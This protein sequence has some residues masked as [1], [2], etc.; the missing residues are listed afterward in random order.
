MLCQAPWSFRVFFP[1]G[2]SRHENHFGIAAQARPQFNPAGSS[3]T[4]CVFQGV[5]QQVRQHSQQRRQQ[6][7]QEQQ[8][9]QH[10]QQQQ[11]QREQQ[12]QA[13]QRQSPWGRS[14]PN[15]PSTRENT[16]DWRLRV[17]SQFESWEFWPGLRC[18]RWRWSRAPRRDLPTPTQDFGA[19]ELF[20]GKAG[21]LKAF[22]GLAARLRPL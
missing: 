16:S 17:P 4:A 2:R 18:G 11:Q 21:G 12:Q 9:Q 1:R 14:S 10:S 20:A 8:K 22:S 3:V 13:Q 7:Q 5:L 6:Q 19:E 15:S